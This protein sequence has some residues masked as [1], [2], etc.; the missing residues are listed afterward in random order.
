MS[1][2]SDLENNSIK[3]IEQETSFFK[4][5]RGQRIEIDQ[6]NIVT[7]VSP[8]EC[9]MCLVMVDESRVTIEEHT[10]RRDKYNIPLVFLGHVTS[11]EYQDCLD[12]ARDGLEELEK[13]IGL[14]VDSSNDF[15]GSEAV[16]IAM[17]PAIEE[18]AKEG[19]G[20]KCRFMLEATVYKMIDIDS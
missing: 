9:P 17:Q 8:D 11:Q 16:K 2:Y 1:K 10:T 4:T 3:L 20:Y 12:K 6:G 15:K 13:V 18:P 14:Q 19:D 5:V 7:K